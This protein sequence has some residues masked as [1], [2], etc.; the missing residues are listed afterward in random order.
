MVARSGCS[1]RPR[2]CRL[3]MATRRTAREW[4]YRAASVVGVTGLARRRARSGLTI[5]MYH[6]VL[7][8]P[9]ARQYLHGLS[10]TP[11]VFKA[12]MSMLAEKCRVVTI[13]EGV[14]ALTTAALAVDRPTV[15]VTFDD[16]YWD[17]ATIAAPILERL[18]LR[19]TFFLTTSFVLR[20]KTLWFDRA[21]HLWETAREDC[22]EQLARGEKSGHGPSF[23]D[24]MS[25][26]K[27]RGDAERIG[28]IAALES[29]HGLAPISDLVAPMSTDD[30][31]RLAAAGHEIGSH[32]VEH[33]LLNQMSEES[34]KDEVWRSRD[35]L[36]AIADGPV[37]GFCYPNGSFNDLVA[38]TVK[39]AGYS[40]A[41][42]TA[43]RINRISVDLFR[44]GR[45]HVHARSVTDSQG[46]H[47][48][49]SFEAVLWGLHSN[50]RA[51][52]SGPVRR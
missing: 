13:A 21:A 30:V 8:P 52:L 29:R 20:G 18:G 44:L 2:R 41:C 17:N 50:L 33:P 40:Y 36:L 46:R 3:N 39:R 28:T 48:P 1:S 35:D 22:A 14:R 31:R 26:L 42:S 43:P 37:T 47:S 34:I 24:W 51:C 5:L 49:E 23:E 27:D 16:G 32:T 25:D 11:D 15:C 19:A 7:E 12:Q 38:D 45:F 4:L 9:L 6:R 10:V